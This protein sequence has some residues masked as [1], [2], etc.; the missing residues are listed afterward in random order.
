M[1]QKL[2]SSEI[3]KVFA[4]YLG[5]KVFSNSYSKGVRVLTANDLGN[6]LHSDDKGLLNITPLS[7][8][9]DEHAIEVA[10]I[11]SDEY[12]WEVSVRDMACIIVECKDYRIWIYFN[13]NSLI[14][15]E[16]IYT[17]KENIKAHG[18]ES[19]PC[20]SYGIVA[21]IDR[22]RE[23]GYALPYKGKDLFE[24]GIAINTQ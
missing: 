4:M 8:I 20:S 1:T 6:V 12:E 17:G 9:T 22:L 14:D 13:D 18:G 15:F 11:F 21:I 10:K 2:T 7:S 16:E 23:L 5:Q 24:L 3:S 19:E